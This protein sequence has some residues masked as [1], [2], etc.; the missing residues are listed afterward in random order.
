MLQGMW[1]SACNQTCKAFDV[2]NA[3]FIAAHITLDAYRLACHTRNHFCRVRLALYE[4]MQLIQ[5]LGR[6]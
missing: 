3:A 1:C 4:G 2:H 5:H 6:R